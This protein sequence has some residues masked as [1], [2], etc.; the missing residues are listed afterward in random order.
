LARLKH[1]RETWV[2]LDTPYRLA[3]VLEDV[4][5][6]VG[7]MRPVVVACELSMPGETVVRGTAS[8]VVEHFQKN[9]FKGE[10]VIIVAGK[11]NP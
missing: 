6:A 7:P 4:R 10:C 9:P 2:V 1:E 3:A 5:D 11:A 8:Q